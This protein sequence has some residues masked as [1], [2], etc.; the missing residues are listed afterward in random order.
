MDMAT[1]TELNELLL[2]RFKNV[3]NITADD[4]GTWIDSALLAEGFATTEDI[5][6]DRLYV[7]MILAQA[8]GAMDIAMSAAHYFSYSDGDEHVDKTKIPFEYRQL[9]KELR[10]KYRQERD[11]NKAATNGVRFRTARRLDRDIT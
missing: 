7:F 1:K 11:R 5:P 10:D 9:E 4:C 8:E 6:Q 2:K 3:P